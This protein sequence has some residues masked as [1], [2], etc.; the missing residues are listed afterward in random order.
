MR[1]IIYLSLL[2]LCTTPI[3]H[4]FAQSAPQ[5]KNEKSE[6]SNKEN[7][8]DI[9]LEIKNGEVYIDGKKVIETE[10]A[11]DQ[12]GN[13]ITKKIIINGKELN[14]EEMKDFES[15]FGFFNTEK[16]K[17][18]LG[19]STKPAKN[20]EGAEVESVVPNSPA[21]K[22]GLQ[23]G[24]IITRVNDINVY[25]PKDLVEAIGTFKPGNE[26]T[27][28]WDRNN[29]FLTK[30]VV[31]SEKKDATTFNGTLPFNDQMFRPFDSRENPFLMNPYLNNPI[32][33]TPKIGLSVE[34]RADEQGVLVQE[35][36]PNSA[37]QKAGIEINDVITTFNANNIANVDE[38]LEAITQAKNK[39]KVKVEL[40][41]NGVKKQ[42]ELTM[43]KNLKKRDL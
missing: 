37:A 8:G 18:M 14:E 5:Q 39:E 35:V 12:Q 1:K 32:N 30:N 7:E 9:S 3:H 23:Q 31:L 41:R 43:P 20:N 36:S 38:L 29:Q 27:L 10:S 19:V 34:D 4:S 25:N 33:Q 6:K 15:D 28:T 26:I 13:K 40:K 22:I 2:L 17:P 11:K 16:N 24:D 42:V 21:Q